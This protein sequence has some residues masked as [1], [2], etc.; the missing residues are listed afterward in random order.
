M[1]TSIRKNW[2]LPLSFIAIGLFMGLRY[3]YGL[4]Y[5]NY[6]DEFYNYSGYRK[7][8]ILFWLFF[9]SFK[10]YYWYILVKSL[11]LAVLLFY[12]TRKYVP[13]K[14]YALFIFFYMI[15]GSLIFTQI[16]AER[17]CLGAMILWMGL[18]FFYFR[19]KNILLLLGSIFLAGL[20]HTIIFAMLLIP[21]LDRVCIKSQSFIMFFLIITLL[22]GMTITPLIFVN[23]TAKI[24]YVNYLDHYQES[25]F[26]LANI[27]GTIYKGLL[28]I[29]VYF[30]LKPLRQYSK[31]TLYYKLLIL[32]ICYIFLYFSGIETDGRFGSI[33]LI[34][35]VILILQRM[36][37][38]KSAGKRIVLLIPFLF[39]TVFGTYNI[40]QRMVSDPLLPGNYLVY[41]TIFDA[42]SL[43]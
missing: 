42:P 2:I 43:P 36:D 14:Y 10:Q 13:E 12:I 41:Q 18:E 15:N 7:H 8:E 31:D 4:D 32:S 33:L 3:D 30:I 40:Y 23:I 29:P 35:F 1:A 21:I 38:L 11:L 22:F 25:R 27:I 17:T 20:C 34:F 19:K 37:G 26:G 28:L 39:L 5:W 9:F 24:D 16:T 6:Y